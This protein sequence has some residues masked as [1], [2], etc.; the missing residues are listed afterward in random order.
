MAL[1]DTH[2]GELVEIA[3]PDVA[4]RIVEDIGSAVATANRASG[5]LIETI[6]EALRLKAWIGAGYG[7]WEQMVDGEGWEIRPAT[8]SDRA[9]LAE[10][11]RS[12]GMSLRAIGK[13]LN[14]SPQTVLRDTAGVPSGTPDEVIGTDG[15]S[16]PATQPERE[17]AGEAEDREDSGSPGTS[18]SSSPAPTYDPGESGDREAPA[19]SSPP[20][21]PGPSIEPDP[22]DQMAAAVAKSIHKAHE[23]FTLWQPDDIHDLNDPDITRGVVELMKV[24]APWWETYKSTQP[25]GLRVVKGDE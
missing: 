10:V 21:S 23:L 13:V 8:T 15:K 25:R 24:V 9:A 1:V 7:S 22:R 16:Y 20:T 12:S 5:R 14:T 17:R 6:A 11:F 18:A 4:R 3:S 2:T 19:A